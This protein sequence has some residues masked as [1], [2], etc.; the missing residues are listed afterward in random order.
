MF[1]PVEYVGNTSYVIARVDFS[2]CSFDSHI[3]VY[4]KILIYVSVCC[5]FQI[6]IWECAR[7]HTEGMLACYA[8]DNVIPL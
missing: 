6:L 4:S 3:I 7:K 8:V 5:Y 2:G 1:K